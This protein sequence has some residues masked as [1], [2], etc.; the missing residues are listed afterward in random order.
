MNLQSCNCSNKVTKYKNMHKYAN[1]HLHVNS[2]ETFQIYFKLESLAEEAVVIYVHHKQIFDD[3]I[4][5]GLDNMLM[6]HGNKSL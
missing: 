6:E 5:F 4:M 2:S 3:E 1:K